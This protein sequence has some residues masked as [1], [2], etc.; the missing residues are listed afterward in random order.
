[1]GDPAS[2]LTQRLH[3]LGLIEF[4]PSRGEYGRLLPHLLI[5]CVPGTLQI[6]LDPL[7]HRHLGTEGKAG[8][9]RADHE[10]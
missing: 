4:L 9:G 8:N 2:E 5:Q 1:M 3:F 10:H 6:R 7:A